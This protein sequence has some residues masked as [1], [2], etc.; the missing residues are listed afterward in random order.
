MDCDICNR[1]HDTNRLPFLCTVDARNQIYE[2]RMNNLHLLIENEA[3]QKQLSELLADTTLP[4]KDSK[5]TLQAQQ[6]LAEDRTTQILAAADKLRNDIKA[7]QEEIKAKKT[8]I[9]RRR[10]DIAAVSSGLMERRAK[11]QKEV[12]RAS[13]IFRYRWSQTAEDMSGTRAFLCREAAHLCGLKRVNKG[14]PDQFEYHLGGLP[15]V[16][17][18]DMNSLSPEVISTSLGHVAHLLMLTSHYLALRLPAALIL[19]HRDHPR[20][21]IF[22]L[23]SSYKHGA[24]S[25]FSHTG[26]ANPSSDTRNLESQHVPRPRPLYVDK[27]LPQL[28]KDDPA[29]FSYFIEGVTL[30]AYD[31][32]WA[33]S[34]QGVSIGDKTYFEDICNMGRNLHSLLIDQ[35]TNPINTAPTPLSPSPKNPDAETEDNVAQTNW[36]GRFSHGTTFY[37]L[38]SAEGTEF[39]KNFKLPGPM[40]L[41]DRLKKKLVAEAPAPDWEVVDDDAWKIEDGPEIESNTT[42]D[43]S[44]EGKNSPHRGS[45]GWM[46]VKNR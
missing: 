3:L 5:E 13:S 37:F 11:Q 32:A 39:A 43:R 26:T 17:L 38:G 44:T 35:Q 6:R 20:P 7:A 30:L 45:S 42:N 9:T 23:S 25:F 29:A 41:A 34:T 14:S 16:D 40:K 10:S 33:C 1:S 15:I 22:T 8:A 12:D 19:P 24:T 18:T 31:I 4:S 46:K 27:P 21:T 36:M 28:A 2:G